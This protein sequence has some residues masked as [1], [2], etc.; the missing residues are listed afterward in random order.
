MQVTNIQALDGNFG[1][2]HPIHKK[3]LFEKPVNYLHL[4]YDDLPED[5]WVYLPVSCHIKKER[6]NEGLKGLAVWIKV[7]IPVKCLVILVDKTK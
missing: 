1:F 2:C 6:E 5:Q 3:P 4:R 7:L